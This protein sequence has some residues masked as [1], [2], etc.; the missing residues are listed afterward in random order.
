VFFCLAFIAISA[1]F[2]QAAVEHWALWE[3]YSS[4]FIDA[5]GRVIDGHAEDGSTSESQAY[6]MFF[7]LVV[8]D[9]PLFDKILGWT[10]D[11]L[12]QG[13]L[14]AHLPSWKWGKD[15]AGSWHVLDHNSASDADLWMSYTLL[16]AGSM[17]KNPQYTELGK[18]LLS[19]IEKQEVF[20]LPNFGPML[21]PGPDGFHPTRSLWILNPSYFPPPVLAALARADPHGPWGF[22]LSS[23]PTM[24]ADT[25]PQGFAM[26]WISYTEGSGFVISQAPD[27]QTAN[28]V[29]GSYDA[30]RVYL[31]IG[32]S[33][34]RTRNIRSMLN[35]VKGMAD[36]VEGHS[37]P[38]EAIDCRGNILRTG[39]PVGFSAA[40]V[41]YLQKLKKEKA[42]TEQQ[43]RL[44]GEFNSSTGL[45]GKDPFYFDQNLAL[46]GVG[47]TDQVFR[48][49]QDGNLRV[50]WKH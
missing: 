2:T 17:W 22:M 45:Y 32:I 31:W 38:P 13:D 48:F 24:L 12:A 37:D 7:A 5:Q 36:Y 28:S 29:C 4:R 16:E 42:V 20:E 18:K 40:L 3:K 19:S 49:D 10:R 9:R 1:T 35:D 43:V 47:Y 8:N 46:F 25:S 21:A 27:R 14:D 44:Q 30:I 39:G 50:R 11:N 26:D 6:A 34:V 33:S 15:G 23:L 41:P